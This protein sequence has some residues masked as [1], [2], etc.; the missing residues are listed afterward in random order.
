M[1]Y[2]PWLAGGA[3]LG[4]A[5]RHGHR[6][7]TARLPPG[8]RLVP[9]A[10]AIRLSSKGIDAREI[11]HLTQSHPKYQWFVISSANRPLAMGESR[12]EAYQRATRRVKSPAE[13]LAL[14]RDEW[15]SSACITS[16]VRDV[17][18][19]HGFSRWE[20]RGGIQALYVSVGKESEYGTQR[21]E[22][23]L[24]DLVGKPVWLVADED[25][26]LYQPADGYYHDNGNDWDGALQ[27][28][29][30]WYDCP[31]MVIVG[32]ESLLRALFRSQS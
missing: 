14:L 23:R 31:T 17:R 15:G 26:F 30:A 32:Q 8:F 1:S 10:Q 11:D 28:T 29:E 21:L 5:A 7:S 25:G 4:L 16:P 2:L 19:S 12:E 20:R 13:A 24:G 27:E 18:L 9:R 6:A 3:A 22:A